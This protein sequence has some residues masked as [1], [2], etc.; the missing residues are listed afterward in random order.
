MQSANDWFESL[1]RKAR[2]IKDA[3][4]KNANI[5]WN[6][7]RGKRPSVG[8]ESLLEQSL[9]ALKDRAI[10]LA[11]YRDRASPEALEAFD[12]RVSNLAEAKQIV[13]PPE[14]L[15][16]FE[17]WPTSSPL[18]TDPEATLIEV[19]YDRRGE[20][21]VLGLLGPLPRV[22]MKF[23][24]Q[25]GEQGILD[26]VIKREKAGE[27]TLDKQDK[28]K[29]AEDLKPWLETLELDKQPDKCVPFYEFK[30]WEASVN[31]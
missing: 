18:P 4:L 11:I 28:R 29:L 26:L 22:K 13:A 17:D 20:V 6:Y 15:D 2:I 19:Y 24:Y 8:P 1:W 9:E 3:D 30:A 16:F 31:S 14:N 5:V 23:K 21:D 27:W 10:Y 25:S 7:R 12:S